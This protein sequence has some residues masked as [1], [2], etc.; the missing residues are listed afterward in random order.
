MW[1]VAADVLVKKIVECQLRASRTAHV[2]GTFPAPD[3]SVDF[4]GTRPRPLHCPF[5]EAYDE[6]ALRSTVDLA[7][8]VE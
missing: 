3:A 5:R 6:D 8:D 1:A 2:R 4:I 7:P